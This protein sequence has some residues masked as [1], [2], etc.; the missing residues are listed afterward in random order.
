MK[1]VMVTGILGIVL[2]V[3]GVPGAAAATTAFMIVPGI[4]G[5]AT[6]VGYEHAIEVSSITQSFVA[7]SKVNGACTVSLSKPLD[8]SG[9][10]L[11]AAA[12]TGQVFSEIRID[13]LKDGDIPL[14]FY[15][16]TLTNASVV[17]ITSSPNVLTDSLT[18]AGSSATLSYYP[19]KPDG[20][21]GP[22][23]TSTVSCK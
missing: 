12:V 4:S 2:S 7:G 10:L 18:L 5:D 8:R 16:L 23:I 13:I 9:P 1:H 17:A 15:T 3:L 21:L 20:S 19:Q 11:W 14:R 22:A 6:V